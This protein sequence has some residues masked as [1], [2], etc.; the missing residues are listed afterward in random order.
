M[1]TYEELAAKALKP[2]PTL[3]QAEEVIKRDYPLKLPARTYIQLWNTPEISQ[4]RGVQESLD[5]EAKNREDAEQERVE[6]RR[7]AREAGATTVDASLLHDALIQ[8][9]QSAN[10]LAT[11]IEALNQT[12]QASLM[13]MA[14]EQEAVLEQLAVEQH[15]AGPSS[16]LAW[17]TKR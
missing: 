4:F 9:R 13:G 16:A 11:N 10:A 2:V 17:R 6:I 14:R 3:T 1:K 5:E 15:K 7:A 12:H 8:Q